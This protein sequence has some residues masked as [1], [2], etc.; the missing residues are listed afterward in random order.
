MIGEGR[1]RIQQNDLLLHEAVIKNEPE[2]VREALMRPTDVNCRNNV[3]TYII[4]III[5][6]SM[7]DICNE[8]NFRRGPEPTTSQLSR[9]SALPTE[10][11]GV[12]HATFFIAI[13]QVLN[14]SVGKKIIYIY[15]II[16]YKKMFSFI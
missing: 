4:Y 6:Y 5:S 16:I 9:L 2:A 8:N 13:Y 7:L 10:Q 12:F 14:S 1:A 3:S 15:F 11:F